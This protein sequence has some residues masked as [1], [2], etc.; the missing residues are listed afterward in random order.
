MGEGMGDTKNDLNFA[1]GSVRDFMVCSSNFPNLMEVLDVTKSSF[2]NQMRAPAP[3]FRCPCE[4]SPVKY[5]N[6]I[7]MKEGF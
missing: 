7:K 2:A 6:R 4:A 1:T 3:F 5:F